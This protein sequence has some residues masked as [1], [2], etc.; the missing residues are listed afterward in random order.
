MS[1]DELQ[2]TVLTSYDGL[3]FDLQVGLRNSISAQFTDLKRVM[4]SIRTQTS[5]D[6]LRVDIPRRPVTAKFFN[7]SVAYGISVAAQFNDSTMV[8]AR[9]SGAVSGLA[10][11]D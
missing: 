3:V 8:D 6:E 9:Q 11:G 2:G 1:N 7:L 10:G 4:A 5:N